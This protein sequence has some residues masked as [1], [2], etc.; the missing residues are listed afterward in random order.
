MLDSKAVPPLCQPS[1]STRTLC[2][3]TPP[4]N[5]WRC[6]PS[7]KSSTLKSPPKTPFFWLLSLP[8][9]ITVAI[10]DSP[11]NCLLLVL[12]FGASCQ[13]TDPLRVWG[14]ELLRFPIPRPF[15][16]QWGVWTSLIRSRSGVG[17]SPFPRI[18]G[19]R[20][21]A[22]PDM[23]VTTGRRLRRFRPARAR[24]RDRDP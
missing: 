24:G 22:G 18:A 23:D 14:G 12:A 19:R 20:L 16:L 5:C 10:I 7:T 9:L 6:A 1:S 8:T 11:V 4:P 21:R 15:S 13:A 3:S 17:I 2:P